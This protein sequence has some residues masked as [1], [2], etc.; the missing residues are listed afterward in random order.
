MAV[1]SEY[2]KNLMDKKNS[3]EKQYEEVLKESMKNILGDSAKE[4]VRKL[5]KEAEDEDSYSEEEV[6]ITK[7]PDEGETSEENP[8]SE[9]DNT[10]NADNLSDSLDANGTEDGTSEENDTE[11][12]LWDELENCK[13][14]DGEYDCRGMN[15]DSLFKVLKVMGPEDGIRVMPNEDGT[16]E[17]EVDGDLIQG[18]LDLV[19]ELGDDSENSI[20]EGK[21]NTGYTSNYQKETAMTT[22][23]NHEPANPKTTY[24]MDGGV[25]T[26]TEKPFAN[27]GDNSPYNKNVNEGEDD[28][29][30]E[31]EKDE[32]EEPV[33]ETATTTEN[34]PYVRGTGKTHANTNKKG[35]TFRNSSEGG[36]Y[37]KGTSKNSYSGSETNESLEFKKKM[38][39]LYE[40]NKQ[41]KSIIPA[42]NKKLTEAMIINAS[43]GYIVRLLNENTTS[44]D[45][46]KQI[47]ERFT[48][49]N[50]LEESKQLY[51]TISEELKKSGNNN[52]NVR[53]IINS[54]LSESKQQPKQNLV[55]TT[56][57]KSE[58]VNEALD[59]MKR[60]DNVK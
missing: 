15:D 51:Q 23:D 4:E 14:A 20:D 54:Q 41:M 52:A 2:I 10:D 21:D 56:M 28:V 29:T 36:E 40:E 26:G 59:F 16:V 44:T 57:Y 33:N 58:K 35:K 34:N 13:G 8:S 55:E 38:N 11:D 25:P 9:E 37:V 30:F 1:R 18:K 45:E 43:M 3:F 46:K 49:V 32:T 24:S 22:P 42:L 6:D 31:I 53:G 48:K 50:T 12:D 47:S 39:K 5:L 60:L 7:T 19:V 17:L 27:Q